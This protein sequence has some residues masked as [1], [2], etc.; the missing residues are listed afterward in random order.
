M[1]NIIK[2][3]AFGKPSRELEYQ[4]LIVLDNMI[5]GVNQLDQMGAV[6]INEASDAWNVYFTDP[7]AYGAVCQPGGSSCK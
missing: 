2:R 1:A 3:D 4:G 7:E 6:A 5:G